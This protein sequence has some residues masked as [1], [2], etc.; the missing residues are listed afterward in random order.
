MRYDHD[1]EYWQPTSTSG[2][3]ICGLDLNLNLIKVGMYQRDGKSWKI[4]GESY[5]S[6]PTSEFRAHASNLNRIKP[7]FASRI[8]S[9][10]GIKVP[11]VTDLHAQRAYSVMHVMSQTN[12]K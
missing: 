5:K 8:A 1:Q 10:S 2:L 7:T 3:S 12:L 4:D 6:I 11:C 9:A